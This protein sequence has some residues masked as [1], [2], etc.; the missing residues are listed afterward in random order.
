MWRVDSASEGVVTHVI[1]LIE[2]VDA[3]LDLSN[4]PYLDDTKSMIEHNF[5]GYSRIKLK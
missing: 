4:F 3:R 2:L 5:N 1:N